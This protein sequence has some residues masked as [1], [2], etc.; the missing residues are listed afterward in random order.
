MSKAAFNVTSGGR[1]KGAIAVP[2]DKSISHRALILGALAD[3]ITEIEGILAGADCRSTANALKALGVRVD[4][5]TGEAVSVHGA[6]RDGLAASDAPLDLGN[7]GTGLRL[8]AGVAAGQPFLTTLTGDA[9]LRR[10]PMRRIV[11]PLSRMGAAIASEPGDVAPLAIDGR[12]PLVALTYE[13]PVA[14]AQLK[15]ALL[16]AG[17]FADGYTACREPVASR[18]HTE[19]LLTHLGAAVVR[20]DGWIGIRGGQALR[21]ACV[22]VP[23]DLSAAAFFIVGASIAP[24]SD[25]LLRDVGVNPTRTGIIDIMKAMG[26]DIDVIHQRQF[27][28]EPVADLH[29]RAAR[30]KG[31][32][33]PPDWV[34]R[35]IDEFPALMIAA[36]SAEGETTV[37]GAGELRV[38]ESDRIEAIVAGLG[39]LGAPAQ[40]APDGLRVRGVERFSGGTIDSR[41][42]H[43]IAMAFTMAALRADSAVRIDDVQNVVTS[44][45]Q[46]ANVARNAGLSLEE[47][48]SA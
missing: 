20:N 34:P 15:S 29:V 44:F 23:G 19:R 3:G 41:G 36:A 6:G 42:D 28:A 45:P 30:L 5:R 43:R 35:A 16:L 33:I 21:A 26:A 24:G 11:D 22:R 18:D 37:T 25:L 47:A 46:F 9:S 10:R 31:I 40:A 32:E 8:L 7:S 13:M 38:K 27:G 17:L 14:S 4:W 12:R 1:L 48:R 39:T 2:G